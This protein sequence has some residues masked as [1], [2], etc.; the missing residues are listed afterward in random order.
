MLERFG[1]FSRMFELHHVDPGK[2]DDNYDSLIRQ[3]LSSK[4]IDE[5]DKCI[6]L[7][8]NCHGLVHAQNTKVKAVIEINYG[9]RTISQKL[10][11][12]L[13]L[14]KKDQLI[15]FLCEEKLLIEPYIEKCRDG[16][17]NIVFGVDLQSFEYF[18]RRMKGLKDGEVYEI[19]SVEKNEIMLRVEKN[20]DNLKVENNVKF[21]FITMDGSNAPKGKKFWYRNGIILYESGETQSE[22]LY[23]FHLPQSKLP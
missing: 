19:F 20:G 17:K 14:D 9:E 12:W 11:G 16:I 22:G 6:L 5:L 2:K 23:T 15:K 4:Q 1:T 13:V 21:G 3:K 8:K 7:C 18:V 10:S